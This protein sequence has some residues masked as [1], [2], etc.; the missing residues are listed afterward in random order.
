M[1]DATTIAVIRKMISKYCGAS[2][3]DV[4]A[5]IKKYLQD[6]PVTASSIGAETTSDATTKYNSLNKLINDLQTK[7]NNIADSDDETLDQFSELVT[8]IK[9]NKS[10]IDQLQTI[11]E[12][13]EQHKVDK[14]V[15]YDVLHNTPHADTVGDF[16]DLR[17]TGKIYRTRFYTFAK[18][19][20]C[21]GTKLLDNAGLQYEP[22]TDTVEGKDDY[23]NG[24]HPLFEWYNCNYK[25]NADGTA[26]PT[27]IEGEDGYTTTG[28]VDVGVIQPS[29]YYNFEINTEEG[30]IDVTISD[31]PHTLRTDI[32]L[33][34]WNECLQ[35]DGTV[36]PWCIGSKYISSIGDDGLLRSLP[37]RQPEGNASYETMITDYQKKGAGYWG[38][39]AER[40]TFQI[41]FILIKGATKN[42]QSLFAGCTDYYIKLPVSI[43]NTGESVY[44]TTNK[45][46][47]AFFV[48]APVYV[49]H[50]G[51]DGH[52]VI[53]IAPT[54]VIKIEPIDS[55]NTAIYLDVK[56]ESFI[57][58]AGVDIDETEYLVSIPWYSGTTDNVIGKH[59]GSMISNSNSKYPYRVQ[60]REYSIG[61]QMVAS[62]TVT[63]L[64]D[65]STRDVYVAPR[66]THHTTDESNIKKNYNLIGSIP[67][68][69]NTSPEYWVGDIK[70]NTNT[71]V[72]FP[73]YQGSGDSQGFADCIIGDYVCLLSSYVYGGFARVGSYG[74][75]VSLECTIWY[76]ETNGFEASAD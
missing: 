75:F 13:S 33:Y 68:Q 49:G 30:Y 34:P 62:D 2:S 31:M 23:L 47:S 38:A 73:S 32:V 72:W 19:P 22:S 25:R 46:A 3:S 67:A 4:N 1:I 52:V 17:R 51:G 74:G 8:Y 27:A 35:A 60:G 61:L 45:D 57:S 63:V 53:D 54:K 76:D 16:F 20:T 48:G 11:L 18:N 71:G 7:L 56:N 15:L 40:N 26:Y 39:G 24:E 59:D 55:N 64:K 65:D 37:D 9:N 58:T 5:I 70:I 42:S 6:N 43:K 10:L 21:K 14:S 66:G 28:N 44:V 50:N 36:L 12:K 41:I 69:E 29:F